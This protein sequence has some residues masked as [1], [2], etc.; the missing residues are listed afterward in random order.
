M[1]NRNL[2]QGICLPSLPLLP[3]EC[4]LK[5]GSLL[6]TPRGME[7]ANSS[8]DL[9]AML[10]LF[11]GLEVLFGMTNVECEQALYPSEL[12]FTWE[13]SDLKAPRKNCGFGLVQLQ[14]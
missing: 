14:E 13:K 6:T 11:P 1:G 4:H 9:P 10:L 12:P 5:R 7:Q 8:C 2:A 3:K